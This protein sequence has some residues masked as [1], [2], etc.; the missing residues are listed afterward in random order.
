MTVE[1]LEINVKTNVSGSSAQ[2]IKTLADALGQLQAKAA[3]LTGLSNLSSLATAMQSISG[4]S[5]K[6]SAFSGIAKGIE[7]LRSALSTLSSED[8]ARLSELSVS[9]KSLNGVDLSGLGNA[10]NVARAA[11]GL[12]QTEQGIRNVGEAARESK[13]HTSAFGS[14]LMRIFK[15][16]MIRTVIK[17]IGQAFSEG[18]KNAYLF[19]SGIVGEGHRFAEAMDSM[20]SASTQMKNQLG[21]AFI[22]LLTAI[23]PVVTA[24]IN[25]VI[26][27]S[28]AIS[29]LFSAFTGTTYLKAAVVSDKFAD[30]MSK[31]AKGAKEWKNQLLGFDVINRLNEPSSGGGGLTPEE[32]FGGEE[33]PIEDKFLKLADKLKGIIDSLKITISDV[34]FDWDDL[35][36]EQIAEKVISGLG[37]LVGAAVGFLLGGVPGAVTGS[38]IGASLG[39]VFSSLIFDHDGVLSENEVL[40]M[41]CAVAG[42]LAG[43]VIGFVVGGPGGAAIGAMIGAGLGLYAHKLIFSPDG[44]DRTKALSTLITTLFAIA[45][46]LIGFAIGGQFGAVIGATVGA[47]VGLLVSKALFQKGNANQKALMSTIVGVLG[48]IAGGLIGFKL[49]GPLGAVIGATIGAGVGLLVVNSAFYKGTQKDAKSLATTL[50]AVLSALVG[51]VIGFALGGIPGAILAVAITSGLSLAVT[52]AMFA[53]S[54]MSLK[55]VIL[56]SL[57]VVLGA[58]VG[59]AIGFVVG[60]PLGAAIGVAIGA[61]ITLYAENVAWDAKSKAKIQS[62]SENVFSDYVSGN[63]GN[64]NSTGNVFAD[65][66]SGNMV[67]TDSITDPLILLPKMPGLFATG[68]FPE[69]GQLF[70][71]REAGPEL[72]G[73]IGGRTAV[74]NND[75]IVQAVSDGVFNAVT[76]AMSNE[77]NTDRPI[78]VRV[79]LD[80][81]EIKSGQ[82]RLNRAMGV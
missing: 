24:I 29:Q 4:T 16:R 71:S 72:V 50:V 68:G 6:A 35:T 36:G 11:K 74:A 9:L 75:Q 18:L 60:G 12:K 27:L 67:K 47:G 8:V 14:S 34:L 78:N 77:N 2:T 15:Y 52:N 37:A 7:N 17:E 76:A 61:G 56:N 25:L 10:S 70:L 46:G 44:Q 43:G 64:N 55:Q 40:R 1:N 41:V 39:I 33:A 32:L 59:G 42:A 20:K 26:R 81:R 62:E 45:G 19:S 57:V 31:G 73:S 48:L 82:Q 3:A 66:A 28:D 13:K 53:D 23:E 69:S 54:G 49:G 58:L 22:A 38:I 21:S 63:F 30:N 51:G 79:Y 5:I 65:Y 80:S